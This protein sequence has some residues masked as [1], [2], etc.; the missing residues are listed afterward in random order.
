M[1]IGQEI[2]RFKLSND[3]TYQVTELT[4]EGNENHGKG[5][6]E[7]YKNGSVHIVKPIDYEM[8]QGLR[9]QVIEKSPQNSGHVLANIQLIFS[10]ENDERYFGINY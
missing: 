3:S 8:V 5:Y 6:L 9:A 4:S 10:D 7:I 2:L 1:P